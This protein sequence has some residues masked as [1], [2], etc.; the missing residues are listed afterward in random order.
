MSADS[1]RWVDAL[2]YASTTGGV[3]RQMPPDGPAT[4]TSPRA[5]TWLNFRTE[6]APLLPA[7]WAPAPNGRMWIVQ[8]LRADAALPGL[9]PA[10]LRRVALQDPGGHAQVVAET[11]PVPAQAG[12]D[13]PLPDRHCV[14]H[15]EPSVS[16]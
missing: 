6:N 1:R 16:H 13:K 3:S 4:W 2:A 10:D 9:D 8:F 11:L 15:E 12:A 14:R 5:G 7:A